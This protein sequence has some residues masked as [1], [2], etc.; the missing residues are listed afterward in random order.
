MAQHAYA[1]S[2]PA[3]VCLSIPYINLLQIGLK[4]YLALL[5]H[6][7]PVTGSIHVNPNMPHLSAAPFL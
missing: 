7:L 6:F 5:R 4:V 2:K 3:K 1:L